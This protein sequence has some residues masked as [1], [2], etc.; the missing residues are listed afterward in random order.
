MRCNPNRK[1]L[2]YYVK[3]LI[4]QT[5]STQFQRPT[6]F[7]NQYTPSKRLVPTPRKSYIMFFQNVTRLPFISVMITMGIDVWVCRWQILLTPP[8]LNISHIHRR[9]RRNPLTQKVCI[10]LLSLV[11]RL[12]TKN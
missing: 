9:H 1:P 11:F 10:E 12:V 3:G 5:C 4:K 7:L 8:H 2:I 6:N